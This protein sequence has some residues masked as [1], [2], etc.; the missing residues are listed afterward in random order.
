M[1]TYLWA[2][3][4]NDVVQL[5]YLLLDAGNLRAASHPVDAH[6]DMTVNLL[7]IYQH[8]TLVSS[9]DNRP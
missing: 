4:P 8:F 9:S 5:Q 3:G 6:A 1:H 2:R 7:N